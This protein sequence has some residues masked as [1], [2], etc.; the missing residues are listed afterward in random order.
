MTIVPRWEWRTFGGDF[1][2]AEERF[3]A[4]TPERVQ[5]SDE[6]YVL[7]TQGD[8]S[9]KV[10]DELMDVKHLEHVNEDGLEQW[11]PVLKGG[12]P[13]P[14]ADASTLFGALGVPGPG[15]GA[16]TYDELLATI[17]ATP[18]LRF[19]DVHKRRARYTVGGC[20]SELSEIS[21]DGHATRTIAIE[22]ED[23]ALVITAVRDL[24]LGDRENTCMA[25]GL[26]TLVG[27]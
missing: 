23:P 25:K 14:D 6:V 7:S 22:L 11:I 15:A 19:V 17:E 10:R 18:E 2:P 26:K 12:F 24:G 8:A 21:S 3:A 1:G 13:L 4:L 27:F 9:V 16:I 20:M 5:E